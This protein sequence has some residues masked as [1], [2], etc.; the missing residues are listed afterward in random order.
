M[1]QLL[2]PEIVKEVT[3]ITG[4]K[5]TAT[6]AVDTVIAM[7]MQSLAEGR[8]VQIIGFGTWTPNVQPPKRNRNPATGKTVMSPPAGR[9]TFKAA[10][11]LKNMVLGEKT[12]PDLPEPM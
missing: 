10:E 1:A 3:R 6:K 11:G 12:P 5:T 2:R 7:M 4:D 8:A 9:V